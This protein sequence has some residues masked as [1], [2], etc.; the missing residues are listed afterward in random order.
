MKQKK[1]QKKK[2]DKETYA[3]ADSESE[4]EYEDSF[5]EFQV[6][7]TVEMVTSGSI[8]VARESNNYSSYYLLK[9]ITPPFT[10]KED[11][12]DGY[13]NAFNKNTDIM[14]GNYLEAYGP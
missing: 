4:E 1:R 3:E 11:E 5:L 7:S 14:T 8:V 12:T 13:G 9:V 10:L 2:G 6:S